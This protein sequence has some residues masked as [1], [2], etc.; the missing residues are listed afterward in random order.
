MGIEELNSQKSGLL[1]S[2]S[3]QQGQ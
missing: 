1:S 3:H 2:I